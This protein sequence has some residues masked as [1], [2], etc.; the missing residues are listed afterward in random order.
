MVQLFFLSLLQVSLKPILKNNLKN[1]SFGANCCK[2]KDKYKMFV[3]YVIKELGLF[4]CRS[5]GLDPGPRAAVV[6]LG[7]QGV[8][9]GGG[10]RL[11][12]PGAGRQGPLQDVQRGHDAADVGLQR[13]HPAV[14][15]ELPS[16]E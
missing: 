6:G 9:P 5:G 8:R 1:V 3:L 14:P 15:P 10:G 7:H 16:A 2:N 11:A 13:R 12:L 4:D